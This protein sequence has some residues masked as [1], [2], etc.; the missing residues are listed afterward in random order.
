MTE[1][2]LSALAHPLLL[3]YH[4]LLRPFPSADLTISEITTLVGLRQM[5]KIHCGK[6]TIQVLLGYDPELPFSLG[7]TSNDLH[8]V[9]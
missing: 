6:A 9:P 7:E 5:I 2:C 3:F 4:H 8:D 1:S